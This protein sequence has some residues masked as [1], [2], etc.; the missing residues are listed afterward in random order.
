MQ[1]SLKKKI[2]K[3][4]GK[5]AKNLAHEWAQPAKHRLQSHNKQIQR[6]FL[7]MDTC[8]DFVEL[9]PLN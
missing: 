4:S 5:T 1:L 6:L 7:K 3:S 2:A 8:P 9:K